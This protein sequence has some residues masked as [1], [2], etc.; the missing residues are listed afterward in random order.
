M[1][2][3]LKHSLSLLLGIAVFIGIFIVFSYIFLAL[4]L[5]FVATYCFRLIVR[6]RSING[7]AH[8]PSQPSPHRIIEHD[9]VLPPQDSDKK[10]P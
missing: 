9:A 10:N 5:I 3:R 8:Q 1:H 4:L 2:P 7:D 6:H